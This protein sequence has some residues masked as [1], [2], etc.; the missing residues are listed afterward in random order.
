V[1]VAVEKEIQAAAMVRPLVTADLVEV[2]CTVLS[3]QLEELTEAQ[4][5]LVKAIPGASQ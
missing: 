4:V 1:A 3:R 2:V 5:H